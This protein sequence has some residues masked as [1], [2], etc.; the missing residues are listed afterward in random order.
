MVSWRSVP[1][2]AQLRDSL[3]ILRNLAG[4]AGLGPV[5]L[6]TR[7]MVPSVIT[8]HFMMKDAGINQ[9]GFDAYNPTDITLT[10]TINVFLNKMVTERLGTEF[11][12]KLTPT[13][14]RFSEVLDKLN[15]R[16]IPHRPLT[17]FPVRA[18]AAA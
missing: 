9:I 1:Q 13:E 10:P 11:E 3:C 12:G 14:P 17:L 6:C 2:M 15:R 16:V 4:P 5:S 7:F 18:P 8:E